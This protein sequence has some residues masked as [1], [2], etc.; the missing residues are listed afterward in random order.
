M[1]QNISQYW[2]HWPLQRVI[3][4]VVASKGGIATDEDIYEVLRDIYKYDYSR[5][6]VLKTIL[7]LE[8]RG[9]LNVKKTGNKYILQFTNYFIQKII[10]GK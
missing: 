7:A 2:R 6:E 8:V 4:D 1:P 10:K 3:I 9:I 5:L